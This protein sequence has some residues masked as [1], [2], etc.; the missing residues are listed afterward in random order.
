MV[1]SESQTNLRLPVELKTWLKKKAEEAHRSLT[2]EVIHRLEES[3]Q[4]DTAQKGNQQ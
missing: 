3:M 4:R 2:P 1:Q